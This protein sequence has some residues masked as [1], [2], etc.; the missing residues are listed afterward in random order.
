MKIDRSKGLLDAARFVPSPN[1]DPRPTGSAVEV[2]VIHNISRPPGEFGGNAIEQLFCNTLD[3]QAH[4]FYRT[5][6][7][8][9][10]SA[11]LLNPELLGGLGIADVQMEVSHRHAG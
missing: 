4:P 7:G 6:D 3:F 5:I 8:L 1:V 10:V 2:L 9:K 11:H